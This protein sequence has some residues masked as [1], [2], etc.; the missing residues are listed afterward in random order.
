[1]IETQWR[2]AGFWIR[3]LAHLVDGFILTIA[4]GIILVPMMFAFGIWGAAMESTQYDDYGRFEETLGPL[5]VLVY[6]L[7]I[8]IGIAGQ[9]LYFAMFESSSQQATPGKMLVGIRV[10]DARGA[11]LNVAGTTGRTLGKVLSGMFCNIGYIIAAFT[12]RKQALHDLLANTYV[13]EKTPAPP[14]YNPPPT[15]Q[16]PAP[17]A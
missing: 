10:V 11:R 12:E 4:I 13:V 1:M 15:Q 3:F 16:P 7:I 5:I 8:G 9:W 6:M 2:Y 17:P 14:V